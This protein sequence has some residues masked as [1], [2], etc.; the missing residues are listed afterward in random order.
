M[1]KLVFSALACVAFAGSAFASNEVS[2]DIYVNDDINT[3]D[4]K[5]RWGI[6]HRYTCNVTIYYIDDYG[7]ERVAY[8]TKYFYFVSTLQGAANCHN[9]ADA[10]A[11][12]YENLF[13]NYSFAPAP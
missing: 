2:R 1:K 10:L 7:N 4:L 9:H 5:E 3:N 13:T 8:H 6:H 11:K 12:T